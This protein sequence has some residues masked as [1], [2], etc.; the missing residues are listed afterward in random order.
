MGLSDQC[1]RYDLAQCFR[2]TWKVICSSI[3][4]MF[5]DAPEAVLELP[6][7]SWNAID[8]STILGRQVCE[9]QLQKSFGEKLELTCKS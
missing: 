6:V 3:M 9:L 1:S 2:Y 7:T 5:C 4:H 8:A